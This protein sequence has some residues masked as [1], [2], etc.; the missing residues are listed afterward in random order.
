VVFSLKGRLLDTNQRSLIGSLE[1]KFLIYNS[2]PTPTN[3][4]PIEK[5]SITNFCG[6]KHVNSKRKYHTK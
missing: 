5:S 3:I 2:N 6:L 4:K 1:K